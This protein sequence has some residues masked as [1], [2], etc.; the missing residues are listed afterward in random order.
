MNRE[1]ALRYLTVLTADVATHFGL[2]PSPGEHSTLL[3]RTLRAFIEVFP[4]RHSGESVYERLCRPADPHR[5]AAFKAAL[6]SRK[7]FGRAGET[8]AQSHFRWAVVHFENSQKP[9]EHKAPEPV[10]VIPRP[11]SA[12]ALWCVAALER[13]ARN[14]GLTGDERRRVKV[15]M[16]EV[17]AAWGDEV[18]TWTDDG[19][20]PDC[21]AGYLQELRRIRASQLLR[22]ASGVRAPGG[23]PRNGSHRRRSPRSLGGGPAAS[24]S[25]TLRLWQSLGGH[26]RARVP[27]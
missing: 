15:E 5:L 18:H 1:H 4:A 3:E 2:P 6:D 26:R 8:S 24:S 17:I 22:R 13:L 16:A 7:G 9:L 12:Q 25:A 21:A 20:C 14:D 19:T 23:R 27:A 10:R 11:P